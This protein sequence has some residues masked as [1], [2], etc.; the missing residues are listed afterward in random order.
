[1]YLKQDVNKQVHFNSVPMLIPQVIFNIR[2]TLTDNTWSELSFRGKKNCYQ[3]TPHC[4]KSSCICLFF[5][6][7]IDYLRQ[8]AFCKTPPDLDWCCQGPALSF[9]TVINKGSGIPFVGVSTD[10]RPAFTLFSSIAASP[11]C[12]KPDVYTRKKLPDLGKLEICNK[13]TGE[14]RNAQ[15]P[16]HKN[17]SVM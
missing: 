12:E 2:A 11:E 16:T 15:G 1:M 7:S 5:A 4:Q 14:L 8:T 9:P 13:K 17:Q 10:C 3:V 6:A